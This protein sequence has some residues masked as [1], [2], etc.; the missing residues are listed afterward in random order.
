MKS[1]NDPNPETVYSNPNILIL[2]AAERPEWPSNMKVLLVGYS[3]R[4]AGLTGG[5]KKTGYGGTVP[6]LSRVL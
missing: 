2:P 6:V 1:R 3:L 5:L 4:L